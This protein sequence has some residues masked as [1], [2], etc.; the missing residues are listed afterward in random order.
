ME[1]DERDVAGLVL[2]DDAIGRL[3]A[4]GRRTMLADAGSEGR[5]IADRRIGDRGARPP[6]DRAG[7]ELEHQVDDARRP[8]L[9]AKKLVQHLAELGPDAGKRRDGGEERIE[10][11]GAQDVSAIVRSAKITAAAPLTS[12]GCI[13]I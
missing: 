2:D 10:D 1:E 8:R 13:A 12:P 3:L 6:V 7:R 4:G 9:V 11:R 5:D